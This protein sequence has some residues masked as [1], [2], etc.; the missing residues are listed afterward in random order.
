MPGFVAPNIHA[1]ADG[2]KVVNYAQWESAEA[3][4]AMLDNPEAQA[5]MG[6]ATRRRRLRSNTRGPGRFAYLPKNSLE[7]PMGAA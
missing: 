4:H 3:F 5:H 2:T 1:S 6:Q 7:P